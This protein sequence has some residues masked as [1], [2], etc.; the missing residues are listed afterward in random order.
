MNN[1]TVNPPGTRMWCR[2][3]GGKMHDRT[4]RFCSGACRA[5]W[6]QQRSAKQTGAPG[7]GQGSLPIQK[8]KTAMPPCTN[9]PSPNNRKPAVNH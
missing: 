8:P 9:K 7:N 2:Q 3:C 4:E 1:G 5:K 6:K